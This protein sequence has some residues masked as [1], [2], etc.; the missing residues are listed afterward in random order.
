MAAVDYFFRPADIVLLGKYDD[1]YYYM[2]KHISV[3]RELCSFFCMGSIMV[4][5]EREHRLECNGHVI[6]ITSGLG[7]VVR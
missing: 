1:R 2:I 7:Y 4:R 5:D 6:I 3:G